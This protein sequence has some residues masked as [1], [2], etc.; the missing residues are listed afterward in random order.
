MK[1]QQQCFDTVGWVTGRT[2]IQ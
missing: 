1:V 2:S